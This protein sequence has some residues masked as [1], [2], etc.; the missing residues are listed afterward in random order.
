MSFFIKGDAAKRIYE[1]IKSKAVL[2]E[3]YGDGT[4]SKYHGKFECSLNIK[5]EYSCNFGVST[6][7]GKIYGAQSC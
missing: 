6:K 1:K 7:E 4:I 2:N 3:C 5:G